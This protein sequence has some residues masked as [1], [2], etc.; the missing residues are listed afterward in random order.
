MLHGNREETEKLTQLC[1]S[2][3]LA[4]ATAAALALGALSKVLARDR[5]RVL[6]LRVENC[7]HCY[8]TAVPPPPPRR[9]CR[10]CEA[11]L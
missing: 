4:P 5:S 6:E 2:Y 8:K 10:R 3:V 11:S 1:F 7:R 9:R